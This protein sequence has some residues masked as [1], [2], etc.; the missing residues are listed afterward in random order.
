MFASPT[1]WSP[2][3]SSLSG[4]RCKT[5]SSLRMRPRPLG[6]TA[7]VVGTSP[8]HDSQPRRSGRSSSGPAQHSQRRHPRADSGMNGRSECPRPRLLMWAGSCQIGY[9]ALA[10]RADG[11]IGEGCIPC[12]V[13]A[14]MWCSGTPV[15]DVRPLLFPVLG[16]TVSSRHVSGQ[17][18]DRAARSLFR[19]FLLLI[20]GYMAL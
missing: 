8:L 7:G 19:V 6:R 11:S 5:A 16:P 15:V 13:V 14:G 20:R 17:C 3:W 2:T 12:L 1:S 10:V 4:L 18:S 9:H